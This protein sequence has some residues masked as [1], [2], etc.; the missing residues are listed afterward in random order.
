MP[1]A[2]YSELMLED[3]IHL[4]QEKHYE[5]IHNLGSAVN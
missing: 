2:L 4:L 3:M 1:S 5:I